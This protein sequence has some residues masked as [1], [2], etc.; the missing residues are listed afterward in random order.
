MAR[1]SRSS[2][3]MSDLP[4]GV[5]DVDA[6][7]M[8]RGRAVRH[9]ARLRGLAL[10]VVERAAEPVVALVAGGSAGVPELLRVGMIRQVAQPPGDLTVP[11][12]VAETE[13]DRGVVDEALF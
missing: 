3:V 2:R 1:S 9:R 5:D 7:E 13:Y 10:A 11:Y 6:G 4:R 8:R 12:Q